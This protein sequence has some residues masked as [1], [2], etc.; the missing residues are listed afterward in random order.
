MLNPE[1]ATTDS[2]RTGDSASEIDTSLLGNFFNSVSDRER[3]LYSILAY[4]SGLQIS[5]H[6]MLGARQSRR[7]AR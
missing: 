7:F 6:P 3:K 2:S 5:D 4:Q 1:I